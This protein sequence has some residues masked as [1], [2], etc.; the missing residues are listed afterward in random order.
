[1]QPLFYDRAQ[2]SG[3][4]KITKEGYFVADALVARAN[5]IQAYRAAELGLTD[6]DPNDIVRVLRPES[7]VFAVDS[8]Q[9]ASRLPITVD[10]PVKDGAAV[11]VDASNWREFAKGET[12][13]EILRDGEFIRVPIR[14]TDAGAVTAVQRDHQEFSL[15]YSARIELTAGV[16]DGQPYDAVLSDLRYNHLAACVAAR[17]GPELRITDERT[18][19]A[20]GV[21]AV[22]IK[23]VDGLPVN[24]A[25]ATVAAGVVDKL[26]ADRDAAVIDNRAHLAT[27][28]TRDG[29]LAT[30]DAEITRLTDELE[31]AKLTP[32]QLRDAGAV[33]ARTIADAKRLGVTVTDEM[34]A[35]DARK[36]AVTAKLG[37]KAATYTPEQIAI[38]F[39]TLV[40]GLPADGGTSPA[41][42][43]DE[44]GAIIGDATNVTDAGKQFEEARGKRFQRFGT[45]H[46][47]AA[48]GTGA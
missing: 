20:Q 39:D 44:L 47:G 12:G 33:Y 30:K 22:T 35:D 13:E 8:L 46:K 11:M 45:A 18:I 36:A 6:R 37:D 19:P 16:H 5:N 15:G 14:V 9:T 1:M 41:P 31:K 34:S 40:S 27:I 3:R 10:H 21:P 17:G 29:E 42:V 2:I 32:A 25:D 4:A 24:L 48:T 7:A 23:V 26:V 43:R 38:A 28:A